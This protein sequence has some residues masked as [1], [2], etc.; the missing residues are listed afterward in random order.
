MNWKE[1]VEEVEK[2]MKEKNISDTTSIFFI[3]CC[4]WKIDDNEINVSNKDGMLEIW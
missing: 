3:D 1:F 4:G 2:Q